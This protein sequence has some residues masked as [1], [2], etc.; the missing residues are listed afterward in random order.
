MKKVIKILTLLCLSLLF[1]SSAWVK[2]TLLSPADISVAHH[3]QHLV[4]LDRTIP[5]DERS[6]M[7]E[8]VLSGEIMR[9][10]EQAIQYTI[11]G[12]IE[13]IQNAP[14]FTVERATERY[15]GETSGTIFP[16]ALPWNVVDNL[17]IKYEADAII[18]VETLDSDYIITNGTRMV[19][20]KD[21]QGNPMNVLEFT[22]EG[23]GIV[24]VGIRL[25]DPRERSIVDQYQFSE[26]MKWDAHGGSV[27]DA[28]QG[29]L[30]KVAAI[31]EVCYRAG[32]IYAQRISPTYY[33]VKRYFY[34]K[35][36]NNKYLAEGVRKSEVA[37]WKG[38]IESWERAIEKGKKDK[39][40]GRA[41]F[42]IAVAYEVLGDL[43]KALEWAARSYTEFGDKDANDYHRTLKNRIN[44]ES[45]AKQQLGD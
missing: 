5:E 43:E 6:N 30:N 35:P 16:D 3:I 42:N 12:I 34:N 45:Y 21:P 11:N 33:T 38:A 39:D 7:I 17:C 20:K 23:V 9:Q 13:V 2:L 37:D 10:D 18:A 15:I 36:K 44:N 29:M 40:K 25:Y 14:R 32:E 1:I 31:N 8:Q 26:Q 28:A 22:V 19:E 41:A 4:V 27:A 24:N